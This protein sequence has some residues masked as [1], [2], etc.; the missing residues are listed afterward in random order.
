MFYFLYSINL[1]YMKNF[2]FNT[3]ISM[4]KDLILFYEIYRIKML[5]SPLFLTLL[6]NNY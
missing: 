5:Q 1:Y 2:N 6:T 4:Y 3:W